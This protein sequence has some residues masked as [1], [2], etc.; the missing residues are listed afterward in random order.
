MNLKPRSV[1][2]KGKVFVVV[3]GTLDDGTAMPE[4]EVARDGV[5]DAARRLADLARNPALAEEFA[6]QL[7]RL[8]DQAELLARVRKAVKAAAKSRKPAAVF[9]MA[10]DLARLPVAEFAKVK[11]ELKAAFGPLLNL[12][13]LSKAVNAVRRDERRNLIADR[14][15]K[16]D[17]GLLR[18]CVNGR[19]LREVVEDSLLALTQQNVPPVVYMRGGLL[20]RLRR[21]EKG[22][23]TIAELTEAG[24]RGRL[25]RSANYFG[26]TGEG[27]EFIEPPPVA[28]VKDVLAL[29]VNEE[30]QRLEYRRLPGLE[31][32]VES[33]VIRPD[34]SVLLAPGYDPGTRLFYAPA[35]ALLDLRVPERPSPAEVAAAVDAVEEVIVDFPFADGP[36]RANFWAYLVTLFARPAVAGKVPLAMFDKPTPG[37]GGSLLA[38]AAV[39][40]AT[41]REVE[42]VGAPHDEDEWRKLVSTM[43]GAGDAVVLVDNV[44]HTLESDALA[45]AITCGEW[46]DRQLGSLDKLRSPSRAVWAVTGNNVA[47]GRNIVRRVY[48]IRLDARMSDPH[49]RRG[50]RHPDLL[51]WI[52]ENRR[53]IVAAILTICRAW[54]AAGKPPADVPVMGSFEAWARTVGGILAHA[55][56]HGFL[57]NLE[58]MLTES[59]EESS[60]WEAFLTALE[61]E[62]GVVPFSIGQVEKDLM[63]KP[64]L[65]DVL[66]GELSV[67]LQIL[68]ASG[69]LQE[70]R[71]RVD[72]RFKI[73]LGKAFRKRAGMRFGDGI[74]VERAGEDGRNHV[75]LW[76]VR[77]GECGECETTPAGTPRKV[78]HS[79][80][81]GFQQ[82]AGSAGSV[83]TPRE[84]YPPSHTGCPPQHAISGQTPP[85]PRTPGGP[86]VEVGLGSGDGGDVP[87]GHV[88]GVSR[89]LFVDAHGGD[90]DGDPDDDDVERSAL[91]EPGM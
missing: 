86:V 40:I 49:R 78:N 25:E 36:S 72:A 16:G 32:V 53:R 21:D 48:Q 6:D 10:E 39:T 54:F 50:F 64:A 91:L 79:A 80:A 56:V 47:L 87:P 59:G 73:R 51:P 55:G 84:Q 70:D 19:Q 29:N 5:D 41:G 24:L 85:T 61:V 2:R 88:N 22:R 45:R 81:K 62:H 17:D 77:R 9:D 90:D 83:C 74:Y 67:L 82:D 60:P 42:M 12:N 89:G 58:S 76:A 13:D 69:P 3:A 8:L 43:L 30:L 35:P 44:E 27:V 63:S 46:A 33:P 34:G 65:R 37:T 4:Q 14:T 11:A 68:P 23:A 28:V 26:V 7:N 20:V 52:L 57:G 75:A 66:P 31:A 18:I 71:V 38:E 15:A 1:E